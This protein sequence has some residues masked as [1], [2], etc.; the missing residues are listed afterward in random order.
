[1]NWNRVQMASALNY[2]ISLQPETAWLNLT[3]YHMMHIFAHA[4]TIECV[5]MSFYRPQCILVHPVTQKAHMPPCFPELIFLA[6]LRSEL[7]DQAHWPRLTAAVCS[8]PSSRQTA[9]L[10][11]VSWLEAQWFLCVRVSFCSLRR[12]LMSLKINTLSLIIKNKN[13]V[14]LEYV[15]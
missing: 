12:Y 4:F 1:M 15:K 6:V 2:I 5:C 9:C 8:L 14:L 13:R 11:Q 7:Q 3:K 10:S